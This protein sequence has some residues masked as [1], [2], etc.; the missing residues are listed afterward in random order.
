MCDKTTEYDLVSSSNVVIEQATV[1]CGNCGKW[2]LI[3]V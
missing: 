2:E 1:E 3:P